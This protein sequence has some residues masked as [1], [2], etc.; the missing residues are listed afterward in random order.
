MSLLLWKQVP[1]PPFGQMVRALS[2]RLEDLVRATGALDDYVRRNPLEESA[3]DA[4]IQLLEDAEAALRFVGKAMVAFSSQRRRDPH[5][6]RVIEM[7]T[8]AIEA[9]QDV[10]WT[11]MVADGL[12]GPA[13][14]KLSR[15][16]SDLVEASLAG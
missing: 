7:L 16:G 10:R 6:E 5:L 8:V 12:Q 11:L 14:G 3:S 15:S 2:Q 9:I 4:C 1:T 13:S